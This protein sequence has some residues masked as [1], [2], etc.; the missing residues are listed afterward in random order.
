M[1]FFTLAITLLSMQFAAAEPIPADA[2][3]AAEPLVVRN[4]LMHPRA[5]LVSCCSNGFS[6]NC[7]CG[8]CPIEQCAVSILKQ[9]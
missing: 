8:S 3:L 7:D 9:L 5:A 2:G 1:Q 4:I 6:G